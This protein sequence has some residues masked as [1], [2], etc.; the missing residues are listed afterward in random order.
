M[1]SSAFDVVVQAS[2]DYCAALLS[3]VR[4]CTM[5]LRLLTLGPHSTGRITMKKMT[6][7]R[8]LQDY[9][10]SCVY[11]RTIIL[12]T[13]SS[14]RPRTS[15]CGDLRRSDG[16]SP[17]YTAN[18]DCFTGTLRRSRLRFVSPSKYKPAAQLEFTIRCLTNAL[19]TTN[20]CLIRSSENNKRSLHENLARKERAAL[21]FALPAVITVSHDDVQ[22]GSDSEENSESDIRCPWLQLSHPQHTALTRQ[23]H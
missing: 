3:T 8:T 9:G 16:F 12:P 4:L 17:R 15:Y 2:P 6:E 18:L 19:V 7:T 14:L 5:R 22:A 23:A 10:L 1:S 13:R 11:C 21:P 20:V